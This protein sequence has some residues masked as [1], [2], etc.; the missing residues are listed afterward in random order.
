MTVIKCPQCT[1]SLNVKDSMLGKTAKC[2][3]CGKPI[4]LEPVMLLTPPRKPGVPVAPSSTPPVAPPPIPSARLEQPSTAAKVVNHSDNVKWVK[5]GVIIGACSTAAV[6]VFMIVWT[7][8]DSG[9]PTLKTKS[10]YSTDVSTAPAASK[11]TIPAE[12]AKSA[13][14][15]L[16]DA[17]KKRIA[18]RN[19]NPTLTGAIYKVGEKIDIYVDECLYFDDVNV[20]GEI[21][22]QA[23]DVYRVHITDDR[24]HTYIGWADEMLFVCSEKL[25]DALRDHIKS[26]EQV[27][28]KIF[29]QMGKQQEEEGVTVSIGGRQVT[30]HRPLAE[31]YSIQVYSRVGYPRYLYDENGVTDLDLKAAEEGRKLR[32]P[33]PIP[34]EDLL[35]LQQDDIRTR[36]GAPDRI[37]VYPASF[38]SSSFY[39]FFAM[40]IEID[41]DADQ[42]VH[43]VT[44]SDD[45]FSG[46]ALGIAIGDTVQDCVAI[47]GKPSSGEPSI[48]S[49]HA[50]WHYKGLLLYVNI[51]WQNADAPGAKKSGTVRSIAISRQAKY[52]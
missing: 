20:S 29:C 51:S 22:K 12:T 33:L 6:V 18:A 40:G 28:A 9:A 37:G 46:K 2:P 35:G 24:D 50:V 44:A 19:P 45:A 41:F 31:I 15:R 25:A 34:I 32:K 23:D 52:D 27:R 14:Q 30:G 43:E 36:L 4:K 38:L 1:A 42:R 11:I 5:S 49:D 39:R 47:W 16:A 7:A 8:M 26:N 48:E 21:D 10:A 17:R 3:A 13:Q